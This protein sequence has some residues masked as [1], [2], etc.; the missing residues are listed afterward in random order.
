MSMAVEMELESSLSAWEPTTGEP[1]ST[2]PC[3]LEELREWMLAI[4]KWMSSL[5]RHWI[6]GVLAIVEALPQLRVREYFV[7]FIEQCHLRL[8]AAL[9]W[10]C[11]LGLFP[12]MK[13]SVNMHVV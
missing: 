13:I 11:Y 4:R 7:S 6:H 2:S 10:M 3:L 5:L 9:I 1:P 8:R 12:A